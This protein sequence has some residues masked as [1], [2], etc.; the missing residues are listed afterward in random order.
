MSPPT[1]EELAAER[2][3][4]GRAGTIATVEVE[5]TLELGA[6]AALSI[7]LVDDTARYVWSEGP[8]A[9]AIAQPGSPRLWPVGDSSHKCDTCGGG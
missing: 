1:P 5:D 3:F 2:W 4:G 6:G 8:V 7:L 9:S